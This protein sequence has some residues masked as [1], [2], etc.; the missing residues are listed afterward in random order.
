[1]YTITNFSCIAAC[2]SWQVVLVVFDGAHYHTHTELLARFRDTKLYFFFCSV[3]RH[4]TLRRDPRRCFISARSVSH[5]V[6]ACAAK[7][8]VP[9]SASG[10]GVVCRCL[11]LPCL[12]SLSSLPF[13]LSLLSLSS[14]CSCWCRWRQAGCAV[15]VVVCT[16][17]LPPPPPLPP[18]THRWCLVCSH[19][20]RHSLTH[21]HSLS[22]SLR[23]SRTCPPLC[24]YFAP[25]GRPHHPSPFIP[26]SPTLH[27]PSSFFLCFP[28]TL[29]SLS[30]FVLPSRFRRSQ[31]RMKRD[32]KAVRGGIKTRI[33]RFR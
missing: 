13:P 31:P 32:R 21:T 20:D 28:P 26:S 15:V 17:V 30:R 27:S 8:P 3:L 24:S 4:N 5:S 9:V 25:P 22:F 1:M 2:R 19:T 10:C 23:L 12:F 16:R 11:S 33:S 14:T 18:T 7:C 29:S 6:V